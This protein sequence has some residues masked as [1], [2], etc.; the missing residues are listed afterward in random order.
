MIPHPVTPRGPTTAGWQLIT[1][2]ALAAATPGAALGQC[3]RPDPCPWL[4]CCD[5]FDFYSATAGCV[6]EGAVVTVALGGCALVGCAPHSPEISVLGDRI[7]F[8]V[9]SRYPSGHGCSKIGVP[10]V[11]CATTSPLPDGVYRVFTTILPFEP[12]EHEPIEVRCGCYADC[13]ASGSLDF[14]DFLCFQNLFAAQDPAA[15]CDAS[16]TLD[17]FDFLCFQNAFAAGCS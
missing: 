6:A 17:F 14:F 1:L 12:V 7:A 5:P 10:W 4:G 8:T 13:D 9:D 3:P 2:V 16:T 11:E 15:D